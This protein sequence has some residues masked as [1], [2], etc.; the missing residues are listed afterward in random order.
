[1]AALSRATRRIIVA[2]LVERG[3][4]PA[5]IAAE[6]RVSRDTVRRDI[7]EAPSPEREPAALPAPGLLLAED[8]QLR[9]NLAVLAAAHRA[10]AEDVVRGLIHR[11]AER[12]RRDWERP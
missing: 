8:P 2:H 1:M 11:A 12:V 9:R 4:N 10:P 6:L 5:V 7:A 3:M